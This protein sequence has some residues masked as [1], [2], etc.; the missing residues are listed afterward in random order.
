MT[1]YRKSD[2][3]TLRKT[4]YGIGFHWT[5]WNIPQTGDPVSFEEAVECFDVKAFVEQAIETGAGHVMVTATHA[6]HKLPCPNPEVDRLLLGRTCKRDLLMEMADGL[7][8]A[9]IKFMLYY[10][11]GVYNHTPN[12]PQD[13][14][15][16]DAIGATEKDRSRYY[17][18]YC[19]V[20]G[21][22]GKHYGPKVIAWWLDSGYEHVKFADTPW[23][24]FTAAA[25][26]G[27]AGRLVTYNSGVHNLQSYTPFQDFWA[28][29]I[30]GL[31]YR[32]QGNET[33][34]SLPW[35]AFCSWYPYQWGIDRNNKD[36]QLPTIDPQEA[37][38]LL[39]SF[40]H[41]NGAVTFNLLC[42][43]DGTVPQKEM[44]IMKE[45]KRQIR[46]NERI[47]RNE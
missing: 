29:E 8:R 33:P 21:W 9:G 25:K 2:Y 6:D 46:N 45:I 12:D 23:D 19:R 28:G 5:T 13:P 37:I 24:R 36:K 42:Y 7:A 15:W 43:Q 40:R 22:M 10:N 3:S 1:E 17:E 38:D 32:P 47:R 20:L 35:Y 30:S 31:D 14:E 39:E 18:N 44:L 26:E 34:T 41:C 16:Q 4:I 27:F 11:H